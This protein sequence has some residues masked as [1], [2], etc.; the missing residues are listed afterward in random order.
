[1]DN[2]LIANSIQFYIRFDCLDCS[3]ISLEQSVD[4]VF[5][6]LNFVF[7]NI[8]F[9]QNRDHYPRMCLC[10]IHRHQLHTLCLVISKN[11][12]FNIICKH[13]NKFLSITEV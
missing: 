9:Y 1:M 2:Y 6:R 4:S 7:R 11:E 13:C 10:Y 5:C 12:A 3:A 8:Y